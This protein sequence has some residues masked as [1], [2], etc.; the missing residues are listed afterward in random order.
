M[1]YFY[2]CRRPDKNLRL[3][4]YCNGIRYSSN[5]QNDWNTLFNKFLSETGTERTNMLSA[6][7]CALNQETIVGYLFLIIFFL[8]VLQTY[9]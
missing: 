7:G 6:L 5:V 9:I 3:Y 2:H 8:H 4:I 1:F